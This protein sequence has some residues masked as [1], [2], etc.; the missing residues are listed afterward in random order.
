MKLQRLL[1]ERMK[2]SLKLMSPEQ[3]KREKCNHHQGERSNVNTRI[4]EN[5]KTK[6]N[7][8]LSIREEHA[9]NSAEQEC[10]KMKR[11][12]HL[13]TPLASALSLIE[14]DPVSEEITVSFAT[15]LDK[16]ALLF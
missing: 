12:A 11:D 16:L 6:P 4:N 15:L 5:A 2:K 7:V 13:D 14:R 3:R 1:K 9:N 8:L 10:V